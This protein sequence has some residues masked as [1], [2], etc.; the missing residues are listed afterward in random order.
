MGSFEKSLRNN[1]HH[2][3]REFLRY[4]TNDPTETKRM[5]GSVFPFGKEKFSL[6]S[7]AQPFFFLKVLVHKFDS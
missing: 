3:Y 6:F 1:K 7:A 4:S 2:L 5:Y